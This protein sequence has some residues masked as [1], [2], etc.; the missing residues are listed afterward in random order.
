MKPFALICF[1]AVLACSQGNAQPVAEP[2]ATF[3]KVS[4]SRVGR[5]TYEFVYRARVRG[6]DEDFEDVT[7]TVTST[8]GATV[9][10]D[11]FVDFGTVLAGEEV[12][13]SDV[14]SFRHDLRVPF[15]PSVLTLTID[16]TPPPE[17]E[18]RIATEID[19]TVTTEGAGNPAG[20]AELSFV[21]RS[22]ANIGLTVPEAAF[23]TQ[24]TFTANEITAV[25][26]FPEGFTPLAAARFGPNGS[27]FAN[28]A[29][30]SFNVSGLRTPGTALVGFRAD[31][32]GSNVQLIPLTSTDGSLS[33]IETARTGTEVSLPTG[34][35]SDI[36]VV[37][38]AADVIASSAG[39]LFGGDL[40]EQAQSELALKILEAALDRSID[41]D[42][43]DLLEDLRDAIRQRRQDLEATIA[44]FINRDVM[45]TDMFLEFTNITLSSTIING[46]DEAL[47][48]TSREE[49][50]A[51]IQR[52]AELAF[53]YGAGLHLQCFLDP[54]GIE[55][56]LGPVVLATVLRTITVGGPGTAGVGVEQALAEA[57]ILAECFNPI[58]NR[59]YFESFNLDEGDLFEG[60]VTGTLG[61]RDT[62]LRFFAPMLIS[63]SPLRFDFDEAA[64]TTVGGYKELAQLIFDGPGTGRRTGRLN[65]FQRIELDEDRIETTAAGT[66]EATPNML[67]FQYTYDLIEVDLNR[68]E[69]E[70]QE[71]GDVTV[72]KA[73]TPRSFADELFTILD[74]ED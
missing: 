66:F 59:A 18:L 44:D 73:F 71:R 11:P 34:G 12:T 60:Q 72:S 24:T 9:V 41:P 2:F 52:T 64:D 32:D 22:G 6:D 7:A 25:D 37:E 20:G 3:E 35:F 47:E 13:S 49:F 46:L 63:E 30:V 17:P 55:E 69:V 45:T 36:G 4:Q 53:V 62:R 57:Q 21:T 10:V 51:S 5:T 58:V 27:V 1:S 29:T 40:G 15:D 14:F 28:A 39:E 68:F 26:G 50:L 65:F 33:L 67:S 23:G 31:N 42:D 43:P 16:G 70:R 8:S 48:L 56:V 19:S 61:T 38:V 74:D 54:S